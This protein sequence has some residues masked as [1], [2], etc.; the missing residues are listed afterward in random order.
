MWSENKRLLRLDRLSGGVA[1]SLS[2]KQIRD[3]LKGEDTSS[4]SSRRSSRKAPPP[5][6]PEL[7]SWFENFRIQHTWRFSIT[8]NNG[9]KEFRTNTHSIQLNTGNIPLSENW[10]MRIGNLSYDFERKRFVY[11]SFTLSRNLH[12]WQMRVSWQPQAD[13]Y[14]FFIGVI[15]EPFSQFLKYE[16]GRTQFDASFR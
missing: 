3:F 12:C 2:L 7:F 1:T 5:E 9:E 8:D 6:Y 10:G 11:P 14:S 13:A 16:T 4:G 15:A